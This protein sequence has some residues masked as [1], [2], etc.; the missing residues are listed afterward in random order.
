MFDGSYFRGGC[1]CGSMVILVVWVV[2]CCFATTYG[3]CWDFFFA[4]MYIF[5]HFTCSGYGLQHNPFQ[6][7][8]SPFTFITYWVCRVFSICSFMVS[9]PWANMLG[10][11]CIK[12][13]HFVSL[14]FIYDEPW[15]WIWV[16]KTSYLT[17]HVCVAIL[18][19]CH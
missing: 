16:A 3:V 19:Q 12:Y 15:V 7:M 18:A 4:I 8:V 5:W 9:S 13:W 10:S 14:D 17:N 1:T 11:L 2:G 6:I